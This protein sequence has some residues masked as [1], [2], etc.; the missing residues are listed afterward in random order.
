MSIA[1]AKTR[2]GERFGFQQ[3]HSLSDYVLQTQGIKKIE[4]YWMCLIGWECAP[5]GAATF[6][7]TAHLILQKQS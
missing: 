2:R 7:L 3:L 5:C 1:F 4:W 6:A